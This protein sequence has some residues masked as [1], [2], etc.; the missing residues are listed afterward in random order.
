MWYI[1]IGFTTFVNASDGPVEE[2]HACA[3]SSFRRN[4]VRLK[5]SC[6]QSG[7]LTRKKAPR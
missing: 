5:D 3:G 4:I 6:G 2:I 7:G 1:Q